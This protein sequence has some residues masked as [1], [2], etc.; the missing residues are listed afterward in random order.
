MNTKLGV[1]Y[2]SFQ[3]KFYAVA[4]NKTIKTVSLQHINIKLPHMINSIYISHYDTAKKV[5]GNGYSEFKPY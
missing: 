1:L 2:V 3:G 4:L 5:K